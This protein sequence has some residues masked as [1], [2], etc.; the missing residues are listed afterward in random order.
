MKGKT[1][2]AWL[3]IKHSGHTAAQLGGTPEQD[4]WAGHMGR[5]GTGAHIV[6]TGTHSNQCRWMFSPY[7]H[8]CFLAAEETAWWVKWML[9]KHKDLSFGSPAPMLRVD[10]AAAP[11]T[12]APWRQNQED[13]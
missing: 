1:K 7:G 12:P 10:V 5:T 11:V 2:A 6:G 13:P 4:I 8:K 3:I 9:R